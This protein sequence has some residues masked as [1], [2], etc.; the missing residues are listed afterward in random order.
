MATSSAMNTSNQYIKYTITITQN[1]QNIPNN[2][3]NV[4]VSVRFYRTNTG[5][6]SYGTGTVYCK[7]N[8]TTYSADVTSSQKIT[9]SGI[10]L[11]AKTL[12]ISHNTDGAKT[13][14][15]SAWISHEVVTSNE[16]SY[17]QTLTTIA[18]ASQP[19]CITYPNN[20]QNVGDFGTTIYIHMNRKSSSFTHTVRYAFG[21][22]S[23]TIATG[24]TDNVTWTIPL[25]LM[26]EIPT[27]TRGWGSIYVDT[28]NG[29]THIGTKSC[30]FIADVPAS[31]KPSCKI[32]VSE[33]T[34]YG[35]YIK[36]FST[37]KVTITPTTTYGSAIA[38]YKSVLN[39]T[40]Y[41][42]SSFTT[43]VLTVLGT[44]TLTA[45][46]TDQRGRSGTASITI[47]VIEHSQ[48]S[49]ITWPQ[50]TQNVGDI[51]STITIH[52]NSASDK[53]THYVYCSW[54]KKT[55]KIA[56]NVTNHTSWTIPLDFADDI[57]NGTSSWGR[58]LVDTYCGS[59][60]IG[61]KEVRFDA[62]VPDWMKP[63]VSLSVSDVMGYY[64][65]YQKYVKGQSKLK[66]EIT[67]TLSY[68][69]PIASYS[70]TANGVRYS[71]ANFETGVLTSSGTMRITATV[72]DQ[73]G[74]SGTAN[75]DISIYDYAPPQI[76][77]FK[78]K[79]CAS[80]EDGTEDINGE[81]AEI[82]F[83]TKITPLDQKNSAKY[84]LQYKK[85]TENEDAY[86]S[87]VL[88]DLSNI[89]TVNECVY[90]FAADSGS[91]YNLRLIATDDFTSIPK[92]ILLSTGEVMEHWRADGKGMG[93]GK[94]GE[95]ENG[96]DFG[97]AIRANKGFIPIPLDENT[98]LNDIKTPNLYYCKD[99]GNATYKN[100]PLTNETI[101]FILEVKQGGNNGFTQI[102]TTTSK[103]NVTIFQR[104]HYSGAWGDW[105]TIYVNDG[106][107]LWSGAS[108]M[109][110]NEAIT[111]SE[112][113]KHQ[114]TGIVL[115]FSA[116]NAEEETSQNFD[117]QDIFV[118]KFSV[119]NHSLNVRSF[120]LGSVGFWQI[121]CKALSISNGQIFGD[122]RNGD[123][124]TQ[125]G[126]TYNNK[127][128]CLRYVIGV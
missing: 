98:D 63:T 91:S 100:S 16:Q 112:Q 90:R 66:V 44:N 25:S 27:A 36:G 59:T 8:G 34:S 120:V 99:G 83:S 37:L 122:Y 19:S 74:R 79:R 117:F 3:S 114:A 128:Y 41:T 89:Y 111:L 92:P 106:K 50:T 15:C 47:N 65:I 113:V 96:A 40:T 123:A 127:G 69:S 10:V 55:V 35:A 49:C 70:A 14:T 28:Y 76:S 12:D 54:F 72:T 52:M 38:S 75:V 21:T 77:L 101:T 118:S 20:T 94:I 61:T 84:T 11:F 119:A 23:G 107:V 46:V 45:T 126:I 104:A 121:G 17:S 22:K 39:G 68:S 97:W 62:T 56:E 88:T 109:L 103:D 26:N 30:T 78:V 43:G 31:V 124:G 73:R 85:T 58:V 81:F 86:S 57:P 105:N 102:L 125:N 115:V 67:P 82:M 13:L 95:V 42:A 116:Y 6:T 51:G 18:R 80:L 32:T 64:D 60:K 24:V 87:V 4:T 93:F 53:F 9:N 5:Y 48:P 2:T 29:S 108:L 110:D 7:I 71:T 33:G 1:S